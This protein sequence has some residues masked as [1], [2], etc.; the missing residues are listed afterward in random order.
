MGSK[1][2]TTTTNMTATTTPNVPDYALGPVTNYFGQVGQFAQSNPYQYATPATDL[3]NQA[4]Q[5][6]GDLGPNPATQQAANALGGLLGQNTPYQTA[7][8]ANAGDPTQ[9]TAANAGNANLMTAANAGN[10]NTVNL[11][12]YQAGTLGPA[13]TYTAQGYTA[14][15]AAPINLD[16]NIERVQAASLLDNFQAYLNPTTQALVDSTLANYDDQAGRQRAAMN[17][18]AAMNKAF[19]GSR[20]GIQAAM[21]DADTARNRALTEAQLRNNAWNTAAGLSSTDTGYR[22]QANLANQAA[23]NSR[24]ETLAAMQAQ[25]NQFNTG[26]INDAS[27]FT[28]GANNQAGAFNAGAQNQYGL[29]QFDANNAASQF[30]ANAFNTGQMFNAGAQND[31]ALANAGFQQTA[32]QFNA[33]AQNDFALADAGFQQAA[34]QFNAGADNQFALTDA[35]FQQDVNLANANAANQNAQ[36]NTQQ[37]LA[38][39][40]ALGSLGLGM[41]DAERANIGLQLAA[42]EQQRD[43]LDEYNKAPLNQ[44]IALGGLLNPGLI[45][46]V[47]GQ[48]VNTNGTEVSKQ[49]GGLLGALAGIASIGSQIAPLFS[50]RR[51][52]TDIKR[53][54]QTDGGLPVYTYRYGGVGPFHMGVMAQ[55]VEKTQ[56]KALGPK[57]AGFMT[58]NYAEI[59]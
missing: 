38:T 49:S 1:K 27:A 47:S 29:A 48:T 35:G 31:F 45:G 44:L 23:A 34:N 20:F 58:V 42:G 6:A 52:K 41:S 3:Q 40:Q 56:P 21:F 14:A 39:A 53:I 8:A 2:K 54:G 12:G 19:G 4:F 11:Q 57:L 30:N 18:Q 36:F 24:A 13:N 25:N 33:G 9:M 22:Q 28:A 17:A 55:E 51:L 10:A 43:I 7:T 26:Q 32:N 15:Q 50:D 37:D 59:N 16:N 5:A 46:S